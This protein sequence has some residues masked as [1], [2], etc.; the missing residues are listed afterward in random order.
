MGTTDKV[1]QTHR[2]ILFEEFSSE[3][4]TKR[5]DIWLD[6]AATPDSEVRNQNIDKNLEVKS[7]KEFLD[8]FA[9]T[10]YEY[11]TRDAGGSIGA[12]YTTDKKIADK[13][14]GMPIKIVDH[15]YY[16]MLARLYRDKGSSGD[17]N[18]TFDADD[19][20]EI[21]TPKREIKAVYNLRGRM[22]VL[23]RQLLDARDNGQPLTFFQQGVI[24]CL[25]EAKTGFTGSAIKMLPIAHDDLSKKIK[26]LDERIN[27]T[28][29]GDGGAQAEGTVAYG[30][31]GFDGDGNVVLLPASTQALSNDPEQKLLGSPNEGAVNQLLLEAVSSSYDSTV[32]RDEESGGFT[33]D[34]VLSVYTT[35]DIAA[36]FD[37]MS[38]EELLEMRSALVKRKEQYENI[39]VQA[40]SAFGKTLVELIQK[41]LGVKVFFD[42]AT[43]KGG[44]DGELKPALLVANCKVSD[45]LDDKIVNHFRDFIIHRGLTESARNKI[46][47]AIVP[48]VSSDE[49]KVVRPRSSGG[50]AFLP[51]I[52]QIK[53]E[54]VPKVEGT[55]F[56]ALKSLLKMTDEAKIMTVFN[57]VPALETTF[58]GINAAHINKIKTKLEPINYE[59]AVFSYPNFTLMSECEIPISDSEGAPRIS[60]P[61][62]Y[63]DAAYVAAGMLV[64]SQQP[65][66]IKKHGLADRVD[67]ETACVHVDLEDDDLVNNLT[68]HFNPELS[69]TWDKSITDAINADQFGF[70]FCSNRKFDTAKND[71]LKNAYVLCARTLC[72]RGKYYQPIHRTLTKDFI[73]VYIKEIFGSKIKKATLKSKLPRYVREWRQQADANATRNNV[74]LILRDGEDIKYDEPDYENKIVISFND[75]EE[76]LSDSDLAIVEDAGKE[77]N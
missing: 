6:P 4:P 7:F 23:L 74:N 11:F 65:L 57:F 9:P 49:K 41:I 15:N 28:D 64:A 5:L 48:H 75:D 62:V 3:D 42:H 55:D 73:I 26:M 67:V 54:D 69:Y 45:L 36:P 63:I 24:D 44:D 18:I 10:V 56:T 16:Q 68:T 71:Y 47:F 43:V 53:T 30:L 14:G 25:E 76:V 61:N 20:K 12:A 2:T 39:L 19:I 27:V 34:L 46:W 72:K 66:Y 21:L 52:L 32:E 31:P 1:P 33:R 22:T 29:K 58:A 59:H 60:V 77:T 13:C 70:A 50:A 37:D 8:K 17:S 51:S 38:R 35:R 40:K